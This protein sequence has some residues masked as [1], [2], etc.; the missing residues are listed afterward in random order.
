MVGLDCYLLDQV[1]ARM[2]F[3]ETVNAI[4]DMKK[5][6]PIAKRHFIE[7][8]ANGSA[9]ITIL[10]KKISGLIPVQPKGGKMSRVAAISPHI[11]SG[12]ILLPKHIG[13]VDD[14]I[15]E[16]CSFP[17]GQTDDIVDSFSQAIN[18]LMYYAAIEQTIT[19]YTEGGTYA[20]GELKMLGLKDSQI[21]QLVKQGKI[22]LLGR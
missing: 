20:R 2:D 11:E 15:R 21:N 13:F 5:K 19:N 8:K 14:F 10:Q 3:V 22:K 9:V 6:Y 1:R 18:Q 7:D 16:C 12:H 17:N 4:E